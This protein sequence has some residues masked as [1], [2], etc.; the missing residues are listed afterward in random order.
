MAGQNPLISGVG[1]RISQMDRNP[2]KAKKGPRTVA[3]A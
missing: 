3:A 2:E 1:R